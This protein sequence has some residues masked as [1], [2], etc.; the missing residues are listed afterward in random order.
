MIFR[1]L[2]SG[3]SHGQCLNVII[4]GVPSGISIDKD[5]INK[6][7]ARRQ[8]GYGRGGRMLI[9]K[10]TAEIL[11]GVRFGKST[12]SPICIV[13]CVSI[14]SK[15]CACCFSICLWSWFPTMR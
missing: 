6:E 12:G 13:N 10:D 5:F 2:T 11:S 1:F 3:E 9:E 14:D 7:L 15:N 8:V 4:E